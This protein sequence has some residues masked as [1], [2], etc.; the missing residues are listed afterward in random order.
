MSEQ[1]SRGPEWA[2]TRLRVLERD[3]WQCQY[4]GKPLEGDDATVDHIV[5]KETWRR[6]GR[7]GSPDTD[8][9]LR[10]ACRSCNSSKGDRDNLPRINYYNPRWFPHHTH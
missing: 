9:N 1:S 6:E 2:A 3:A 5:S 10:A 8:D 7:P 4:C